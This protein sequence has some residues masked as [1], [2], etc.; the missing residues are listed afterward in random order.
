MTGHRCT[1]VTQ[2]VF[3]ATKLYKYSCTMLH[4]AESVDSDESA[5]EKLNLLSAAILAVRRNI[6]TSATASQFAKC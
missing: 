2:E 3:C 6:A 5:R 1:Y 4:I